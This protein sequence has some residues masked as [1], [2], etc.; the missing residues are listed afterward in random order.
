MKK[1]IVVGISVLAVIFMLS[2]A[3]STEKKYNNAKEMTDE[4][5]TKVECVSAESLK[6]V[7]NKGEK[8]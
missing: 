1:S 3:G 5:K 7:I 4:A 8:D 6:A 2:C